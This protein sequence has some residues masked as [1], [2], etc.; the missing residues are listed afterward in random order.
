MP[1]DDPIRGPPCGIL[2]GRVSQENVQLVTHC[3]ELFNR[4]EREAMLRY[5]DP[6]IETNEGVELPGATSYLGPEGVATAYEHWARQWDD[7]RM[8]LTEVIDAGNDVVLVTRHHG[9]GRAS[10]APVQ[11]SVAYVFTVDDGKLIRL[12]IFNTKAQAM[13]AVGLQE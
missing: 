4:G 6:G 8:E 2:R 9:T 1:A 12:R 13:E 5:V 11:T 10:G 7:F 3:F